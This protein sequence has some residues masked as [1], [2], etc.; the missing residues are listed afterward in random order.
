MS[1]AFW[2]S[3]AILRRSTSSST[4]TD[5]RRDSHDRAVEHPIELVGPQ[6]D[7]ERLVPRHVAQRHVDR[8]LHC[9]IDDDVQ[10]ADLREDAEHSPEIGLLEVEADGIAG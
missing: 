7:V 2:R 8:A 1:A 10:P 3:S 5:P 6:N 9:R 4:N